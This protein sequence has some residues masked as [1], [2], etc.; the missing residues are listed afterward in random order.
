[1]RVQAQSKHELDRKGSE[2]LV[3]GRPEKEKD[4]ADHALLCPSKATRRCPGKAW[5]RHTWSASDLPW[6]ARHASKEAYRLSALAPPSPTQ[7]LASRVFATRVTTGSRSLHCMHDNKKIL[8]P[9]RPPQHQPPRKRSGT[10]S[11]K[12]SDDNIH[13]ADETIV[14]CSGS[15]AR[16]KANCAVEGKPS[17]W[18]ECEFKPSR[19]TS[20]TEEDRSN[21]LSGDLKKRMMWPTMLC[22]AL[23]KPQGEEKQEGGVPGRPEP[24]TD[25]VHRA[26][27]GI[28]RTP[29]GGIRLERC[30]TAITHTATDF[31]SLRH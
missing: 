2:Q 10:K 18:S 29:R 19:S 28:R 1:M 9:T 7:L 27:H 6:H 30:S 24:G 16:R 8:V 4:V 31:T 3:V 22:C 25:G 15:P 26:C 5:T 21:T 23:V 11:R 20:S 14:A 13:A 12:A 17:G